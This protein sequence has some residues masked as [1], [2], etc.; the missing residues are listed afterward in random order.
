MMGNWG[1]Y[2]WWGMG[3]GLLFMILF[4]AL[5]ILGIV[6]LVRWLTRE[7]QAGREQDGRA[8]PRNK[9]PLEIVQER[10]ARGEIDRAEYEQKRQDLER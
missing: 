1:E 6:A 10:Y 4:W 3:F 9:T 8:P 2:G 5:V 7:A